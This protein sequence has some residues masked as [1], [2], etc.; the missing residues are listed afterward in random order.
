M[1]IILDCRVSY[2]SCSSKNS[3]NTS[4][5]HLISA[6][7]CDDSLCPQRTVA[8][9][10]LCATALR[11]TGWTA[12]VCWREP[13]FR[14]HIEDAVCTLATD[15]EH[16]LHS[17]AFQHLIALRKLSFQTQQRRLTGYLPQHGLRLLD[18]EVSGWKTKKV[19]NVNAADHDDL[20]YMFIEP[21]F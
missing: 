17:V 8:T 16:D 2:K 15:P 7:F 14:F 6:G 21:F 11:L 19:R 18:I 9:Q 1:V 5:L 3:L 12:R 20:E 10:L 4:Y 13:D